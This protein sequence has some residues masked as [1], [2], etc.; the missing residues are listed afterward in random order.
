MGFIKVN[1]KGAKKGGGVLKVDIK[2]VPYNFLWNSQLGNRIVLL[3]SVVSLSP[4]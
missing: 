2:G 4:V 3:P 1:I